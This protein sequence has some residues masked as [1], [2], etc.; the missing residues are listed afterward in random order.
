M[1]CPT[2]KRV[3]KAPTECAAIGCIVLEDALDAPNM[4]DQK[5]AADETMSKDQLATFKYSLRAASGYKF[6]N[7]G[8]CTVDQHACALSVLNNAGEATVA[9]EAIKQH[10]AERNK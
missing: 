6:E 9:L 5:S 8:T 4:P 1:I 10:R 7:V 3:C 2:T